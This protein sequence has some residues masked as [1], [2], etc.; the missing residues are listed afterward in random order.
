MGGMKTDVSLSTD[1]TRHARARQYDRIHNWLFVV[2]TALAIG[3]LVALIYRGERGVA[4]A[5]FR[6]LTQAVG[7]DVWL[8]TAVY[9]AVL[10]TGYVI[11]LL[12]Y[13]WFKGFYL[14]H[15]FALSTQSL[16]GWLWDEIKASLLMLALLVPLGSVWY[17]LMRSTGAMWWMWAAGVWIMLQVVLGMVFPVLILPLFY[18]SVP[19]EDTELTGA[20]QELA[21]RCGVRVV[22]VYRLGLSAKTKKANAALAGFGATKRI[23]LGDTLLDSFTPAEVL[24]VLAHEFGHYRH[25][26]MPKLIACAA[27]VAVAGMWLAD[28]VM[29]A[30]AAALGISD[31]TCV[32]TLPLLLLALTLFGLIT[33]P[34]TNALSRHFERQSDRFALDAT[35]DAAAFA[36]AMERLATSNLSNP[37]PHPVIEFLLHSHPSIGRRI[38]AA[39]AWQ[40]ARQA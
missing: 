39:R 13:T 3:V 14:E 38:A 5:L 28:V 36:G 25:A 17:W 12:P 1:A 8:V 4:F 19:L 32:A 22:G 24:S 33:L 18:R 21:R 30:L 11:A 9:L 23:F 27:V 6:L 10:L 37:D 26:H 34:C 31:I 7:G 40:A 35:G 29:R 20:V 16:G 2:D 15:H